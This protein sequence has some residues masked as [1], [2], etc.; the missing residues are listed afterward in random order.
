MA[1]ASNKVIEGEFKGKTVLSMWNKVS[2]IV[3]NGVFSQRKELLLDKNTV[4]SYELID[5][6]SDL[7]M[8]SA[9]ARSAVGQAVAGDVGGIAGAMTAKVHSKNIVLITYRDGKKSLIEIDNGIYEVL[10]KNCMYNSYLNNDTVAEDGFSIY[11]EIVCPHCKNVVFGYADE[12]CPFCKRAYSMPKK[13]WRK[14]DI[15][16]VPLLIIF[17]PAGLIWMWINKSY[18]LKTRIIIT[19]ICAIITIIG[20]SIDSSVPLNE[21]GSFDNNIIQEVI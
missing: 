14:R 7:S 18:Y 3:K 11:K 16:G 20:L 2:I 5:Y 12:K 4:E 1:V 13:V 9:M 6:S 21:S 10:K 19:I 17:Y 8:T 15:I